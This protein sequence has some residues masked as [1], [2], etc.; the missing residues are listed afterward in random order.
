MPGADGRSDARQRD[1]SG[2]QDRQQEQAD[3]ERGRRAHRCRTLPVAAQRDRRRDARR[4]RPGRR[5]ASTA[6]T[7]SPVARRSSSAA[8]RWSSARLYMPWESSTSPTEPGPSSPYDVASLAARR[9]SPIVTAHTSTPGVRSSGPTLSWQLP[10]RST[11]STSVWNPSGSVARQRRPCP[12]SA[13]R[14]RR[15]GRARRDRRRCTGGRRRARTRRARR[16]SRRRAARWCSGFVSSTARS[17]PPTIATAG[18]SRPLSGPTST[19]A[20]PATSIASAAARRADAGIDDG[21]HDALG[22]VRDRPGERQRAAAHVERADAVGQV[23][24]RD[25]RRH[26]ADDRLDDADELVVEAVVGEERHRVVR[27]PIAA[28]PSP[29]R[30]EGRCQPPDGTSPVGAARTSSQRVSTPSP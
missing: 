26:V 12:A 5:R 13:G 24:D 29:G 23:D 1:H 11:H 17:A 2:D 8:E 4:R 30:D 19:P 18:A 15:A 10:K 6:A 3:R 7:A 16:T 27:R 14:C 9:S 25:V 21:E 28:E 20:P 22:D